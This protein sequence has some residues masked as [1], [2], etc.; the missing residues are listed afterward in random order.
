MALI[1]VFSIL[2]FI[3]SMISTFCYYKEEVKE[4]TILER[5][6]NPLRWI[7]F[8]LGILGIIRFI[9]YVV[10]VKAFS[11]GIIYIMISVFALL[12]IINEE[13]IT[14]AGVATI[15][16]HHGYMYKV[17]WEQLESWSVHN[18]NIYI[19]TTFGNKVKVKIPRRKKK[20]IIRILRYD[21]KLLYK[22]KNMSEAR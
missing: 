14:E 3:G 15:S 5:R 4:I 17:K 18:N 7:I 12:R 13:V 6:V 1:I 19:K 8:T 16:M 2:S 10:D 22:E 9:Y 11:Y 20:S 21:L